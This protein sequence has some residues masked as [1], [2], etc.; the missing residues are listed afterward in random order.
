MAH[1]GD[2]FCTAHNPETAPKLIRSGFAFGLF[3]RGSFKKNQGLL[4][5]SS[6]CTSSGV[7]TGNDVLSW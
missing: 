1:D 6:L 3:F 5:A 2:H 4:P 7:Y